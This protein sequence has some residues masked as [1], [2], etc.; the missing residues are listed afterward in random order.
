MHDADPIDLPDRLPLCQR[1]A[2]RCLVYLPRLFHLLQD[3]ISS[4]RENNTSVHPMGNRMPMLM[5]IMVPIVSLQAVR[6]LM[7]IGESIHLPCTPNMH[8]AHSSIC[9][10]PTAPILKPRSLRRFLAVATNSLDAIV[11][12]LLEFPRA[13]LIF[14]L[15]GEDLPNSSTLFHR[16]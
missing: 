16:Y 3:R 15:S 10:K 11:D 8:S 7:T 1:R 13:L 2:F 4:N 12:G 9:N 14:S 5:P 6:S